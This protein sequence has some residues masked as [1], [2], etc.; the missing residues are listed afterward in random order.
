MELENMNRV[1]YSDS[2]GYS[3][4]VKILVHVDIGRDLTKEEKWHVREAMRSFENMVRAENLRNDPREIE[5][6]SSER[7]E[8]TEL[9]K[10]HKIF[11][12]EIQ[13]EY[14]SDIQRPWFI[15]T[16]PAGRIKIGWR[17]RVINIDW[18]DST[19]EQ[20]TKELFESE[21]VTKGE[22]YIHAWGIEKAQEYVNKIL[23]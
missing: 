14:S 18:S 23:S 4:H 11:V 6:K 16:T 9:F 1:H 12:E 21:D 3:G 7:V 10:G 17:K 22:K 2:F 20:T 19:I 8:L 15:V 5:A 13:N